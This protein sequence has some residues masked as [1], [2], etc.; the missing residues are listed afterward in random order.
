MSHPQIPQDKSKVLRLLSNIEE[1][2]T[3][4]YE[5]ISKQTIAQMRAL[6]FSIKEDLITYETTES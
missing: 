1:V 5:G 6:L 2:I 3:S 4:P